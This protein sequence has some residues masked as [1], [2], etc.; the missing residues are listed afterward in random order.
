MTRPSEA[1]IVPIRLTLDGKTGLTL[2]A[3]PWEEDGEEWQAFLGTGQRLLLFPDAEAVADY[4][5]SGE[6]NDLSDHPYYSTLRSLPADQLEPDEDEGNE[7]DLDGVYEVV[8]GDPDPY[9]VSELA[10]L[11]DMVQRIA[12]VCDDGTLLRLLED[13]PEFGELLADE[14]SYAGAAGEERWA[15]LGEAVSQSWELVVDRVGQRLEWRGDPADFEV[16]EEEDEDAEALDEADTG[17][18]DELPDDDEAV[19]AAAEDWADEADEVG[20]DEDEEEDVYAATT[21][22]TVGPDGERFSVWQVAGIV[23][24]SLTV[25]SGNGYTLRTFIGERDEPVFLGADLTVDVFR[26]AQ[27]LVDY[28]H[29]EEHHDL[30]S[31]VTWPDIRDSEELPVEP[32]DDDVY[33]LRVPSDG[34]VQLA[35]DL[36][37][38]CDLDGVK[39]ALA[40]R[41]RDGEIPF[42]LWTTAVA[43]IERCLRWRD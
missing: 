1:S 12:E 33:D 42:D 13:T 2:W 23:P 21:D 7:Y 25:P 31:M 3:T 37:D 32:A 15:R 29:T 6:E 26:S 20:I 30:A 4:L 38:Y 10:D 24:I 18:E 40:S 22:P 8:A 16:R 41:R 34:A 5:A 19:R 14:V 27:G 43:E 9:D 39:A 36:A 11:V 28:C 17:E 35:I